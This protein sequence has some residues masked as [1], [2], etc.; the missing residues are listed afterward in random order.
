MRCW[1]HLGLQEGSIWC[2]PLTICGGGDGIHEAVSLLLA[3]S[4]LLSKLCLRCLCRL[5]T[6]TDL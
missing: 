1:S 5:Q 6:R 3:G 2:F 4:Q